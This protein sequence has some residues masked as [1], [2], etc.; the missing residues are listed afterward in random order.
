[1]TAISPGDGTDESKINIW[2]IQWTE[3]PGRLHTIHGVARVG[4]DL[5]AKPP[6]P[7]EPPPDALW[8]PG[9]G[10]EEDTSVSRHPFILST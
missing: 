4:H 10:W 8:S 7:E 2:R 5:A 6:P 3:K 1:M 9:K